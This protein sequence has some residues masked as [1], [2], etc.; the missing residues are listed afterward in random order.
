VQLLMVQCACGVLRPT[1]CRATV[2]GAMR[3]RGIAAYDLSFH[4]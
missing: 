3:L 4:C 2:D 1:I